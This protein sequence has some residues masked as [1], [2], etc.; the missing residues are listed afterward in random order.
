[1]GNPH[2]D[3]P[4]PCRNWAWV[5]I[6]GKF[7]CTTP[8][9]LHIV[10]VE[11]IISDNALHQNDQCRYRCKS[12]MAMRCTKYAYRKNLTPK[13]LIKIILANEKPCEL[14]VIILLANFDQFSTWKIWFWTMHKGFFMEEMAQICQIFMVSSSR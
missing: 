9:A 13:I 12:F 8:K 1:M 14:V 4:I 6:L 5:Q 10:R 11:A 7:Q 3:G 2:H